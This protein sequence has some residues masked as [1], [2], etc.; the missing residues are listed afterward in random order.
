[1]KK[2]A[3]IG[4]GYIGLVTGACLADLGNEVICVDIKKEVVETLKKG[5]VHFY[6]PGLSQI[7]E[8]NV[9][10]NRLSFTLDLKHAV[11]SSDIIFIAVG[12]PE[13]PDGSTNLSY[14]MKACE[15]VAGSVNSDKI[16]VMKSTVPVGTCK[17]VQEI[18][19]Q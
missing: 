11:Q 13:L 12:T 5:V 1:M 7:I 18:F 6:E 15:D 19:N 17:K 4:T 2:I 10:K 3:V 14:V 16:L 9:S 8:E